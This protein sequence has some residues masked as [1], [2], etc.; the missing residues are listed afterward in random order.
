MLLSDGVGVKSSAGGAE[1]RDPGVVVLPVHEEPLFLSCQR[2]QPCLCV[3]T[4]HYLTAV[5]LAG[6][7]KIE[8]ACSDT[9][10]RRS[11]LKPRIRDRRTRDYE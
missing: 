11:S 4:R 10:Q 2:K 7:A 8:G 1:V 3:E 5:D 6:V 9:D